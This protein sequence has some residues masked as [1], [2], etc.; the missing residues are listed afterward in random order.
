MREVLAGTL[1]IPPRQPDMSIGLVVQ[2]P[3][4][5]VTPTVLASN[6]R[7]FPF[8]TQ[9]LSTWENTPSALL[10]ACAPYVDEI[11]RSPVP[12]FGGAMNAI[13]Q[14]DSTRAGFAALAR[15]GVKNAFKTRT[16]QTIMGAT[17]MDRLLEL[18]RCPV[19]GPDAGQRER[20]LFAPQYSWRFIPFHLTDQLQFGRVEDMLEFWQTR[21]DSIAVLPQLPDAM[22]AEFM[23]LC[24]PESCIVRCYLRRIGVDYALTLASY[25]EVLAKRF[26]LMPEGEV[27]MFNWKA[28]ALFDV[29]AQVNVQASEMFHPANLKT[30][31]RAVEWSALRKY[32]SAYKGLAHAVGRMGLKVADYTVDTLFDL[33]MP[34]PR[35]I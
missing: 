5:H 24:T 16:D 2:G 13:M 15:R 10:D 28:I 31:W 27:S 20:I 14:R 21:D 8:A 34:S 9:I 29:P 33:P 30:N 23:A 1:A 12:A 17:D 7:K 3:V 18:A 19:D 11:V 25:W 35:D 32:P 26:A 4:G 22:A 6:R